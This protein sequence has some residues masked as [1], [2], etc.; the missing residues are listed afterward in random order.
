MSSTCRFCP[1]LEGEFDES[2]YHLL[3]RSNESRFIRESANFVTFPTLGPL[4]PGHLLIVPKRH[5]LSMG[6]LPPNLS[7]EL[8]DF[9]EL[10]LRKLSAVYRQD[11]ILF[12]HGPLSISEK[13]GCCVDHAHIH[14]IPAPVNIRPHAQELYEEHTITGLVELGTIVKAG[15]PYLFFQNTAGERFVYKAPLVV[16]QFLRMVVARELGHP[17]IWDWRSQ[18]RLDVVKQ[19]LHSLADW[20]N[21]GDALDWNKTVVRFPIACS[22]DEAA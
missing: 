14:A 4:V 7:S 8:E 19:T 1:E 2:A 11:T 13:G 15:S 3:A 6:H 16:S 10:T 9:V 17:N 22:L 20:R 12:E 5:F 21:T 18:P